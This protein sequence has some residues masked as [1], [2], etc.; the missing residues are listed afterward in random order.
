MDA[1]LCY[2]D[3]DTDGFGDLTD[4]G[5]V[6]LNGFCTPG[7]VSNNLDCDDSNAAINP[8]TVWYQDFDSDGYG[9]PLVS[10]TQ[11]VQPPGYVLDNTDCDDTDP[12]KPPC[13]C[14]LLRGDVDRSGAINVSDLTY[15]VAYLFSGGAPPPCADEGDVDGSGAINVSDLT[16]LVAYLFSGGPP[17]PPC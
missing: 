5:T 13:G 6:D 10:L 15:L 16:Y 3:A 2:V 1:I 17:P 7:K 8:T 14:C 11:C 12:T 4:P 9:N